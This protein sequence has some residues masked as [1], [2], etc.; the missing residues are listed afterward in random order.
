MKR[1]PRRNG[2]AMVLVLVFIALMLTFYSVGYRR[3]AATL[4]AETIRAQRERRDEGCV[5]AVAEGLSL[6]ETGLPPSNP[7]TCATSVGVP[8]DDRSFTVTFASEEE[9]IWSVRA[10]PTQWPDA[11]EPMPSSF[12]EATSP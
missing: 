5:Q 9:G 3:V 6:L 2:Y 4:R 7:Y 1:P 12:G 10:V 11:P 8:P